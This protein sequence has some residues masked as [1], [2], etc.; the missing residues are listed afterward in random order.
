MT[1]SHP[2]ELLERAQR[3]DRD[4]FSTLFSPLRPD[5]VAFIAR[6]TG[7][8]I[9][10]RIEPDDFAQE[11]LV[12]AFAALDRFEWRGE[13]SLRRWMFAVAEHAIRNES[14]RRSIDAAPMSIEPVAPS[15]SPSRAARREERFERLERAIARLRPD[16]AEVIRLA[17]VDGLTS[18]EIAERLG[19]SPGRVRHLLSEALGA[20]RRQFGDSTM[21]L[22]LPDR[23]LTGVEGPSEGSASGGSVD[24]A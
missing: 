11:V 1:E 14:R 21:S 3:G 6:Q 22:G 17:R 5:L 9:R 20:L 7:P 10:A 15:V 23:S 24:D 12:T 19:R 13:E 2:R 18:S 16:H 8:A 4:A